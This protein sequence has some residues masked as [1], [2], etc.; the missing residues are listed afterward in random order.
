MP[1]LSIC[2]FPH[3]ILFILT[4]SIAPLLDSLSI[5]CDSWRGNLTWASPS[6]PIIV[7]HSCSSAET[8]SWRAADRF[9]CSAVSSSVCLCAD[10]PALPD[11][12]DYH[13]FMTVSTCC[14]SGRRREEL[15]ISWLAVCLQPA[16]DG[17]W[18]LLHKNTGCKGQAVTAAGTRCCACVKNAITHQAEHFYFISSS[19]VRGHSRTGQLVETHMV[20]NT[21]CFFPLIRRCFLVKK[22]AS[23]TAIQKDQFFITNKANESS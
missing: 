15:R 20:M 21:G 1:S 16:E 6:H 5:L 4:P 8:R 13:I 18:P 22:K 14:W 10:I 11:S 12:P 17:G 2:L 3:P 23:K 9:H 7:T 19:L